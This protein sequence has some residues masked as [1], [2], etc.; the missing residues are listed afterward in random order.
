MRSIFPI[1]AVAICVVLSGCQAVEM[2]PRP[3]EGRDD[4]FAMLNEYGRLLEQAEAGDRMFH[5]SPVDRQDFI[6][7][8][9]DGALEDPDRSCPFALEDLNSA[10]FTTVPALTW[11]PSAKR[12]DVIPAAL[13]PA[14]NLAERLAGG[15]HKRSLAI[16]FMRLH[17]VYVRD[18]VL[19]ERI[20]DQ[21]CFGAM[22][23]LLE[24]RERV[25]R[26][27]VIGSMRIRSAIDFNPNDVSKT[28]KAGQ[29]VVHV[30][31]SGR[32]EIDD[33]SIA[34]RFLIWASVGARVGED[35]A[36]MK[37]VPFHDYLFANG[38]GRYWLYDPAKC[39]RRLE[40]MQMVQEDGTGAIRLLVPVAED[41]N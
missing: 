28:V 1:F 25:V 5:Y 38:Y 32:Y 30:D 7:G 35:I 26:G 16:S 31:G 6:I 13:M 39:I 19:Q 21:R 11:R 2:T 37:L 40:G 22:S 15:Q 27:L 24:E 12:E 41:I 23:A 14:I 33:E 9:I 29:Y 8:S 34:P 20:V 18:T 36:R 17:Q 3:A 4:W 10:P